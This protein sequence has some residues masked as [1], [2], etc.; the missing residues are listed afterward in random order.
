MYNYAEGKLHLASLLSLFIPHYKEIATDIPPSLVQKYVASTA[1][2]RKQKFQISKHTHIWKWSLKLSFLE[3]P[4]DAWRI[5]SCYFKI[6]Y[7]KFMIEGN[8][9]DEIESFT[10]QNAE[11]VVLLKKKKAI[12]DL[13]LCLLDR[14]SSW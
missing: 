14:A 1:I 9:D 2:V 8:I 5:W 4:K 3:Y 13:I 10:F 6:E 12:Q 7:T 11:S